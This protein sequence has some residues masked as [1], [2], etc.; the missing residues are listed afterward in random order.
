MVLVKQLRQQV[1]LSSVS[2]IIVEL[3]KQP[4]KEHTHAQQTIFLCF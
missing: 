1:G 4:R 2:V 3:P